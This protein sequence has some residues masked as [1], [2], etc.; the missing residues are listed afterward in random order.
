MAVG[1]GASCSTTSQASISESILGMPHVTPVR[2]HRAVEFRQL[3]HFDLGVPANAFTA[4]A[5]LAPSTAPA[6]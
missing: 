1:L 6:P 2:V 5:D 4:V 3:P